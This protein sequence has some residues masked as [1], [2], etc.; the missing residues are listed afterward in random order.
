MSQ[1][2]VKL[3]RI[4]FLYISFTSNIVKEMK[5]AFRLYSCRM[6]NCWVNVCRVN[7]FH[8]HHSCSIFGHPRSIALSALC[9]TIDLVI[10]SATLANLPCNSA[11]IHFVMYFFGM[12]SNHTAMCFKS[13]GKIP[14]QPHLMLATWWKYPSRMFSYLYMVC[15]MLHY[16]HT[17]VIWRW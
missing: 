13:M 10:Q 14:I 5:Q 11:A 16:I 3:Q 9:E 17:L 15:I 2:V 1:S 8:C 6:I 4:F 12:L 7:K